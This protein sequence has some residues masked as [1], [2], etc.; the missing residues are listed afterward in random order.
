MVYYAPAPRTNRGLRIVLLVCG[1]V[2]L[3]LGLLLALA[4]RTFAEADLVDVSQV[5]ADEIS[6]LHNYEID[7]MVVFESYASQSQDNAEDTQ[8]LMVGYYDANGT[9]CLSSLAVADGSPLYAA[10]M[11]YLMDDSMSVGDYIVG[12][13]FT[14][15]ELESGAEDYFSDEVDYVQ[16]QLDDGTGVPVEFVYTADSPAAFEKS[17]KSGAAPGVGAG[18]FIAEV[19]AA[20]L[21][22]AIVLYSKAKKQALAYGQP[23]YGQPG[24][25]QPAYPQ[26]GQPVY[27]RPAPPMYGQ[28]AYGQPGYPQAGQPVYGQPVPPMYGQPAYGQPA[29]PQAGQPVQRFDTQTGQPL[30]GGQ[31]AAPQQ[32]AYPQQPAPAQPAFGGTFAFPAQQPGD[33]PVS[34]APEGAP[35]LQPEPAPAEA[36]PEAAAA[37]EAAAP[38]AAAPA[39]EAGEPRA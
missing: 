6:T 8:F 16:S 15:K 18:L 14:T 31:P 29:Y 34:P 35:S 39:P 24:Y 10:V 33:A 3:A 2:L 36:A 11:N 38:E 13:C 9:L 37:S 22:A 1:I 21:V 12:G 7:N 19:G 5:S 4:A 17:V 23:V 25:G 28:P 26:A 20:L 27:G 30:Y 32:P